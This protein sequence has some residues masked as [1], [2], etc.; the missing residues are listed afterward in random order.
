MVIT[1]INLLITSGDNKWET[2]PAL[3]DKSR[4][5]TEYISPKL[6]EQY[7]SLSSEMIDEL[8]RFPCVFA[9]EKYV[10]KDAEIGY[11]TKIEIRQTNVRIDFELTGDR[12]AFDDLIM[13]SDLLDMGS[14]EWNRTHWTLKSVSLDDLRP[15]YFTQQNRHRPTAFVSYCW[16]PPANQRNVF[17]LISRL[18]QDGITV[19]YDKK[20][21]RPGQDMNYFME[22]VLSSGEIDS[23]IIVCNRDYA[24]KANSRRGGVGYESELILHEIQ[25][26]PLQTRYIPV[27]IERDERGE[28]PLPRFLESRYCIDLTQDT[29]YNE[30]LKAICQSRESS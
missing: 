11:I 17:T 7:S 27:V 3:F 5:L 19:K 6:R 18:E 16:T 10:K 9:Y 4:C 12:I 21:L 20:D 24:E 13:L 8:K 22:N 30:L 1:L 23:V 2:S 26:D 14:W 28:M 29:G 15:Y 25:G